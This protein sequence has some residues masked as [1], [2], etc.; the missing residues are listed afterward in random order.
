MIA[1]KSFEFSPQAK[2]ARKS[3]RRKQIFRRFRRIN[4]E[5]KQNK[6]VEISDYAWN[7]PERRSRHGGNETK[8]KHTRIVKSISTSETSPACRTVQF[9]VGQVLGM[10][11][12]VSYVVP[13]E[14]ERIRCQQE[15]GQNCFDTASVHGA[16]HNCDCGRRWKARLGSIPFLPMARTI[17]S[18]IEPGL[19]CNRNCT[20]K[21]ALFLPSRPFCFFIP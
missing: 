10:S 21:A 2:A 18:L 3:F 7:E 20:F 8:C 4:Y 15:G 11:G 9:S 5:G 14:R 13:L 16:T 17:A 6:P 19:S 1:R 12:H